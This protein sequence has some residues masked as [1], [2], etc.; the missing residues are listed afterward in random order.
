M[1]RSALT[2]AMQDYLKAIFHLSE[3]GTT[4]STNSLASR[5]QVAAPSVTNM[6]KRLAQLEL[7]VHSPYHGIELTPA[8]RV[9]AL[10]V[11]RHHRLLELYLSQVLDVPWDRVHEEAE[12]LEH[13]ISEDLEMRIAAKLGEP[14]FDP[15]GDPIPH[16]S[17]GLPQHTAFSLWESPPG[18]DVALVRVCDQDPG[19]L[20][21]LEGVHLRPGT[22]LRVI[23][24][25]P[26]GG[27]QTVQVGGGECVIGY[28]LAKNLLVS[29]STSVEHARRRSP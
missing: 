27:T 9:I 19:L 12:R 2:P 22:H 1:E 26:Y 8:G 23:Q 20:L 28:E 10:E 24:R 29:P 6:V 16:H 3:G 18:Q 13:V 17:G 7:V 5:L 14:D 11:I 21:Y 15:H 4:T 25:S